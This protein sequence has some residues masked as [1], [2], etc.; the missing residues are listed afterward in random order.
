LVNICS[1]IVP[2]FVL[3]QSG[4]LCVLDRLLVA[5]LEQ[6][7][8]VVGR[9]AVEQRHRAGVVAVLLHALHEPLA[10]RGAD[11]DVVEGHVVRGAAAQRQ[12]VIVDHRHA[13]LVGLVDHRRR[14]RRVEVDDQQHRRARVEHLVGDRGELRLVAVGVLDVV[15]DTRGLEGLAE[16]LAVRR[17][18]ARRRRRVGEDHA[19]LRVGRLLLGRAT[20]LRSP[21]FVVVAATRCDREREH[22][23]RQQ[24][25]DP[26]GQLVLHVLP[27]LR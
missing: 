9:G 12:A 11:R 23:D 13:L 19:D 17:L 1:K 2:A 7:G 4:T 6:R 24:R 27:F 10:D 15:L 18:P 26:H 20:A 3:S 22:A 14:A 25:G 21:A 16:E 8:V 5:L